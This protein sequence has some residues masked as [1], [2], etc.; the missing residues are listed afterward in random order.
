METREE[1][2]DL[3]AFVVAKM[4]QPAWSMAQQL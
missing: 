2:A 3:M 1:I 4:Q